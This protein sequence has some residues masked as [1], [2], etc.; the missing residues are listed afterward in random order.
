MKKEKIRISHFSVIIMIIMLIITGA[1][2]VYI[3]TTTYNINTSEKSNQDNTNDGE[4]ALYNTTDTSNLITPENIA[5]NLITDWLSSY[6]SDKI[7]DQ[8]RLIEYKIDELTIEYN[9]NDKIIAVVKYT[10]KPYVME[11]SSWNAGNG[12]TSGEYIT[13]KVQYKVIEKVN[14]VYVITSSATSPP[15]ELL[16]PIT[17]EN[18]AENLITEW[19]SSYKSDKINDQERLSEYKIDELTIE[20][21]KNDKI[22]AVVKYTVKP[23]VMENSS[24]NAGN[25]ITSGEYITNK[26]QYKVIEKVNGLYGIT[27]SATSPPREILK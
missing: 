26:V 20:Y 4:V 10:V 14:G 9:A 18:M 7:N 8:E 5:E 1:L 2:L 13:N 27:S 21:N 17:P 19:L 12:I 23:Y 15:A 11:N 3:I 16:N 24:W 6:K 25:G 22:I